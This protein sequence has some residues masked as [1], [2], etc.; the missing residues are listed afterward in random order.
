MGK[1][2][3]TRPE[4]DDIR[5]APESGDAE[6]EVRDPDSGLFQGM[7]HIMTPPSGAVAV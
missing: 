3:Q 7:A 6:N 4:K 1:K 5:T 2:R